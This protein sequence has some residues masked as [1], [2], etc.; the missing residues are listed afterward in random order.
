M[1]SAY[2][3]SDFDLKEIFE[4]YAFQQKC[5]YRYHL[6]MVI[7]RDKKFK[8][9]IKL[10]WKKSW[11]YPH[12]TKVPNLR[13]YIRVTHYYEF[14]CKTFTIFGQENYK[15]KKQN[16]EAV[17]KNLFYRYLGNPQV[18][19][20]VIHKHDTLFFSFTC[21]YLPMAACKGSILSL[22]TV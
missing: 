14:D 10:G 11:R 2:I 8:V 4:W 12:S 21:L 20:R 18:F 17:K 13:R 16:G 1:K 9:W 15:K 22:S 6:V 3:I 7:W 19:S 5:D